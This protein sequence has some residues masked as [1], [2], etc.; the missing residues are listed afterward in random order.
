LLNKLESANLEEIIKLTKKA[1][2]TMN[3]WFG[4]LFAGV[5]AAVALA[6]YALLR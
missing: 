5:G 6:V 3:I 4:V 1:I 2:R